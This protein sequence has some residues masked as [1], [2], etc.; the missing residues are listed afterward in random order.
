MAKTDYIPANDSELLNWLPNHK[1]KLGTLGAT[2]GLTA[3]E[4]TT[5]QG[6][7][8]TLIA[9]IQ[10]VETKKADLKQAVQLKEDSKTTELAAIRL[11]VQRM[12]LHPTYTSGT[13]EAL[14]I[15]GA[16]DGIDFATYK[17]SISAQVIPQGICIKFV[18]SQLDGVNVYRRK[19]GET[20]FNFLALDTRSPYV[21]TDMPTG[22]AQ[23]YEYRVLG[24]SNDTEVGITSD[25]IEIAW[26]G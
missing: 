15:E 14:G 18:K 25:T 26:A 11:S 17:P 13:G 23:T 12:K 9:R 2:L 8:D 10:T 1:T 4:V 20:N 22:N 24:V 7:C 21:D 19:K 6:R 16:D 5:L 3:A